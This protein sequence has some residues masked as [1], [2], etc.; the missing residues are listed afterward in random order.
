MVPMLSW[1]TD[2][3]TAEVDFGCARNDDGYLG[4]R[5]IVCTLPL[6]FNAP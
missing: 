6:L 2:G 1:R 5:L 4:S 3:P